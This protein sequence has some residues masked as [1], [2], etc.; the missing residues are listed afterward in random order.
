MGK[1]TNIL[2]LERQHQCH[3]V[4]KEFKS[5][6]E[7]AIEG[8]NAILGEMIYLSEINIPELKESDKNMLD[9]FPFY[10]ECM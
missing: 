9:E 7:N 4:I 8:T 2:G 6:E 3:N 10:E 1:N 5:D